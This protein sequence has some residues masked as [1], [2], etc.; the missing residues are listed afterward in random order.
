MQAFL[1][2]GGID[3][4]WLS[5]I[6]VLLGDGIAL[7]DGSSSDGS[8]VDRELALIESIAHENGIVELRYAVGET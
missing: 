3:E 2:S 4:L 7:F 6:P 5:V 8:G 1:R